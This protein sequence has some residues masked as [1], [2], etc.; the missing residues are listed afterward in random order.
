MSFNG[1]PI[2]GKGDLGVGEGFLRIEQLL[3]MNWKELD[4]IRDVTFFLTGLLDTQGFGRL[5]Y[6]YRHS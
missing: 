6:G 1:E 3:H 2:G 5:L 4:S